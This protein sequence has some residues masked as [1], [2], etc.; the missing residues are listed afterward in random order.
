MKRFLALFLV[1]AL[2]ACAGGSGGTHLVSGRGLSKTQPD[3]EAT[4]RIALAYP[5]THDKLDVV[6]YHDGAY[7]PRAMQQISALM[8]DRHA[9]VA[10][11]ID[12][13][14][15]DY[16]VDIRTRLDLPPQAVFQVL[17]GYR[18]PETN[19]RLAVTN[20]NVAKESLHMHGWAV[21]FRMEGVNG[22]AICAIA[23][24]MQRGGVAYYPEDNHVHVDLGNI[25]TWHEASR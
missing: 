1:F 19:A 7:D 20:G 18:T 23:E 16:M 2:C 8:R 15:I 12:P 22:R 17:S 9:N 4:R 24:T 5:Y 13:A 14:L 10:G 6:Y 21:D 25:R 11:K 3:G